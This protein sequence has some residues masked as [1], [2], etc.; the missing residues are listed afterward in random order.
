MLVFRQGDVAFI[1]VDDEQEVARVRGAIEPRVL[2]TRVVRRGESGGVHQLEQKPDVR[3]LEIDETRFVD[4]PTGVDILGRGRRGGHHEHQG[5][6]QLLV[7]LPEEVLGGVAQQAP[8]A[9]RT[10][11]RVPNP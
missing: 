10:E 4:A 7:A 6:S 8:V 2:K 1:R 5:I 11:R 9:Q 3:F